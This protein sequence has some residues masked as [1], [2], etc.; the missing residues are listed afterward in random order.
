MSPETRARA[1]APRPESRDPSPAL[2]ISPVSP[3]VVLG[4]GPIGA[5]TAQ[6]AALAAVAPL[7]RIVDP[8]ADVAR[9]IAL[10]LCQSGAVTGTSTM[11][12]GGG[13]DGAVVGASV[14]VIADRY[15]ATGEW[16]GD[17]ALLLVSRLRA[18]NP[19]ALFVCAGATHGAVVERLVLERGADRARI[20][21][22]APE[23]LRQALTAL[24]ALEAG[25]APRDVSLSVVGRSPQEAFVPWEG[26]SVGG[27]R[28]TE[29]LAPP[30]VGRLDRQMPYLWPPGPLSLGAAAARVARLAMTRA[31]GQV[32][33][34][35][36]PPSEDGGQVRGAVLP[37]VITDGSV[38]PRPLA[39]SPRERVR[40]D[41]AT[42]RA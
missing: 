1:Q 29:V 12:E 21:G 16:T 9:G 26:A 27:A 15:G 14:V 39:L 31:P 19:R 32:S 33:L 10:D 22:S 20:A 5:A 6:Q 25:V 3:L 4:A 7:V 41:P 38:R 23:A 24:V 35:V 34:F 30:V 2:R 42:G 11:L 40:F 36:V 8:S 18:L 13:D 28:A 17:E 37:A